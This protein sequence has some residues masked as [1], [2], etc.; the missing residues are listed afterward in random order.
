MLFHSGENL[1]SR[2]PSFGEAFYML[3]KADGVYLLIPNM[4]DLITFV[5]NISC[6]QVQPLLQFQ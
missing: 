5:Q 6:E 4:K 1:L 3:L 2:S